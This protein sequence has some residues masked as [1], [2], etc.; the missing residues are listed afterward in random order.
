MSRRIKAAVQVTL[1]MILASS[2]FATRGSRL[3]AYEERGAERWAA[4]LSLP[5]PVS[6]PAVTSTDD[7]RVW[8]FGGFDTDGNA[9]NSV[10]VFSPQTQRWRDAPPMPTARGAAAAVT[11]HHRIYVIGGTPTAVGQF[12]VV[13]V[14][15][16]ASGTWSTAPSMPTAR[17]SMAATV[18]HHGRIYVMGGVS[19]NASFTFTSAVE[20]FDTKTQSWTQ[21]ASLPEPRAALV[22]GIGDDERAYA[23][24]GLDQ[25]G[26]ILSTVNVFDPTRNRWTDGPSLRHAVENM[27][28]VSGHDG[29][30]YVIGGKDSEDPNHK[31]GILQV[32]DTEVVGHW[33]VLGSMPTPRCAFGAALTPEGDLYAIGGFGQHLPDGSIPVLATVE[34]LD[35]R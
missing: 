13:E 32:L 29:R 31:T 21:V 7:G 11:I 3:L 15:D 34:V 19:D 17:Y 27:A 35:L 1:M 6:Y 25:M 18:D 24:G 2:V 12:N 22:A 4:G 9:L 23:I 20:V 14:F 16:L 33:G 30:I 26:D 10:K 5:Q 28:A 8:A